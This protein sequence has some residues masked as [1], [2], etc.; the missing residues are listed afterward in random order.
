MSLFN[1]SVEELLTFFAVLV[2]YSVLFSVL[3]FVGDRMVPGPAKVLLALTVS[4]TL[5]PTLVKSGYVRPSE[6]FG[7]AST[8][9]GI[10]RTVGAEVILA[11]ALGFVARFAFE[12]IGFGANLIG[13]FMGLSAAAQYDPHQETQSQ[14]I[15]QVQ[16]SLAML[17]F[18]AL[19]GHHLMLRAALDSYAWIGVGQASIGAAFSKKLVELTGQVI[20]FGVELAAPVAIAIFGVN[21]AFGVLGKAM[22]Q[23][24]IFV[25]SF[26]VTILVGLVILFVSLPEFN[27]FASHVL[28]RTEGAMH[29]V[30]QSLKGGR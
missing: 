14:V 8:T 2:R 29:D 13:G 1:F 16:T 5:F 28:M 15:A 7:W 21:V 18:L 23:M 10:A 12:S 11:L 17:L 22:P 26:A 27:G 25:L 19:D 30:I 4:I 24:N 20:L 9:S 3:P 6:A